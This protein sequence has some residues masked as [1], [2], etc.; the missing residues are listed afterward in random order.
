MMVSNGGSRRAA[1]CFT[2]TA[3]RP[4][5]S[6]RLSTAPGRKQ[7]EEKLR[8]SEERLALALDASHSG[9]WDLDLISN[10]G[11]GK[12]FVSRAARI[13]RG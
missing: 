2:R 10:R 7:A 13:L 1:K 4:G 6:A 12:R 5:C 11:R 8:E 3:V 9:V